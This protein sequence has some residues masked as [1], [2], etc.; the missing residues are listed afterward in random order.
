MNKILHFKNCLKQL[1]GNHN[2]IFGNVYLVKTESGLKQS[3]KL[4]AGS[5]SKKLTFKETLNYLRLETVDM[6]KVEYPLLIEFIP[7]YS[8][9]H[10]THVHKM[11]I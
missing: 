10:W 9:Y 5:E 8:G 7:M 2:H 6:S 3:I 11:K 4:F 1:D